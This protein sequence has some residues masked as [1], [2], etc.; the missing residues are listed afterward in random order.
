MRF[1]FPGGLVSLK[2]WS[3]GLDLP[4]ST[5]TGL[6]QA[7]CEETARLQHH[8]RKHLRLGQPLSFPD[9]GV[10]CRMQMVALTFNHLVP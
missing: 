2:H 10:C 3:K 8:P 7:V 9:Q 1:F 5:S 6:E 4:G